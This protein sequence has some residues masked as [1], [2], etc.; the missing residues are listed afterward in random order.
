MYINGKMI[1]AGTI[2]GMGEE[3]I[4]KN[5]RRGEWKYYMFDKK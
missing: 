3:R 4:K 2:P 5:G 1:S